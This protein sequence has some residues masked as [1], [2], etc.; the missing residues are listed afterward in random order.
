MDAPG[1]MGELGLIKAAY[2]TAA[3]V[4]RYAITRDEL[5]GAW[6][7]TGTVTGSN[8]YWLQHPALAFVVPRMH[9]RLAIE[10][11]TL[12]PAGQLRAR[13]TGAAG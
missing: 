5:S 10:T 4:T 13:L 1:L 8:P 11:L 6:V 3:T 2:H 9:L 7:L 12:T